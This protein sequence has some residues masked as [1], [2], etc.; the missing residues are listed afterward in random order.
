MRYLFLLIIF[1]IVRMNTL[2]PYDAIIDEQA[3]RGCMM[4]ITL[5]ENEQ[6]ERTIYFELK[7]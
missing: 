4:K 3:Y 2:D 5:T 6:H 1:I 7:R